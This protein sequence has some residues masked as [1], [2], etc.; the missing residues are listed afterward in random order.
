MG[1]VLVFNHPL[2]T[3]E[4]WGIVMNVTERFLKYISY[5]TQSDESSSTIPS[6]AK[7]KVLGQVLANEERD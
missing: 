2:I 3:I 5:D 4:K 1:K 7:Q 6:T